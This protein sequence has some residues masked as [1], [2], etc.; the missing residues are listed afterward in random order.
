MPFDPAKLT[1]IR[2]KHPRAVTLTAGGETVVAVP[3]SR[4]TWRRFKSFVTNEQKRADAFE[5]LL[6][7]CVVYP[8]RQGLEAILERMPALAETF[9][10]AV[11][12]LAGAGLE[13]EKNG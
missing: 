1:E 5:V 10:D 9:G 2:E 11:A 7:D 12:E 3:P 6:V 8:D 4:Q 13:V